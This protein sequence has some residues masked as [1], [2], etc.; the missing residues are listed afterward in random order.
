MPTLCQ[1]PMLRLS[2]GTDASTSPPLGFNSPLDYRSGPSPND[3]HLDDAFGPESPS[4]IL[5]DG[6]STI[7]DTIV[8]PRRSKRFHSLCALTSAGF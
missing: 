3:S 7:Q 6:N 5:C 2:T 1:M 8:G 4:D